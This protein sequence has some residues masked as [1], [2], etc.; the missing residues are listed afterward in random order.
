MN[1]KGIKSKLLHFKRIITMNWAIFVSNHPRYDTDCYHSEIT[2]MLKCGSS[3]N[4]FATY[5]CSNVFVTVKGN[6]K[7]TL[8]C[9]GKACPQCGKCYT[10]E[11]MLKIGVRLFLRVSYRQVVLTLPEQLRIPF[12]NHSN[13]KHL[14]SGFM[15]LTEACLS[16]LIQAHFKTDACETA[17]IIFIHTH[18]RNGN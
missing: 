17:V 11:S 2:K 8:C 16:E 7:L 6:I 5:Q 14:Y 15:I 4:G 9:K 3:E 12:H 1:F 13:Q 18:C 10:R